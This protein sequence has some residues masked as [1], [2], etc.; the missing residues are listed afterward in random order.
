MHDVQQHHRIR[1][2]G[3]RHDCI[4]AIIKQPM[5]GNDFFDS[6]EQ[7]AHGARIVP[8]E[9]AARAGLRCLEQREAIL[10]SAPRPSRPAVRL[11]SYAAPR[12]LESESLITNRAL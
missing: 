3:H 1:T 10:R 5:P 8:P 12:R 4:I 2:T 6:L 7:S 11:T 9:P